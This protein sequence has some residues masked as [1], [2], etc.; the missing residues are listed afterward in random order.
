MPV[1]KGTRQPSPSPRSAARCVGSGGASRA[2][3]CCLVVVRFCRRYAK[4]VYIQLL[5]PSLPMHSWPS[6]LRRCVQVAVLIGAG[7]NPAECKLSFCLLAGVVRIAFVLGHSLGS[8]RCLSDTGGNTGRP[9]Y[10]RT[11]AA[12]SWALFQKL[13]HFWTEQPTSEVQHAP[14]RS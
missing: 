10:R 9:F 6:G 7:S 1:A 8:L 4:P 11:T 14:H 5:L 13:T 3:A 12:R 2:C